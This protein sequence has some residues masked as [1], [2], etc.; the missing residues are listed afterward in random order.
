MRSVSSAICT[1]GEPVSVS[2]SRCSVIV[3][4]L[5]GGCS[6]RVGHEEVSFDWVSDPAPRPAGAMAGRRPEAAYTPSRPPERRR[7]ARSA[8]SHGSSQPAESVTGATVAPVTGRASGDRPVVA[9]AAVD[10]VEAGERAQSGVS[11]GSARRARR[12]WPRARRRIGAGGVIDRGWRRPGGP[13]AARPRSPAASRDPSA[14]TSAPPLLHRHEL[15]WRALGRRPGGAERARS[16]SRSPWITNVGTSSS[17]Q[18]VEDAPA[19]RG[20]QDRHRRARPGATAA[21][22]GRPASGRAGGRASPPA[23]DREQ[24]HGR[25]RVDGRPSAHG[26]QQERVDAGRR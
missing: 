19:A 22:R 2:C 3:P 21:W 6:D 1:S 4:A 12:R 26:G 17:G 5:G 8:F 25:H 11:P 13:R 10:L 18:L 16:R 20:A 9:R 14:A 7:G 24:R 15:P 23:G